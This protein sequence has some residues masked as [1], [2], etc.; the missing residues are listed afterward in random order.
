MIII[1]HRGNFAGPEP[2]VENHPSR[3]DA[4]IEEGFHVE[5]DLRCEGDQLWFGHDE[6]QYA[7]DPSWIQE[8][9]DRLF[10]H[11][12]DF[13]AFKH[14]AQHAPDRQF[15]CHSADPYTA[16]WGAEGYLLWLHDL[17]LVPDERT[18]VPLLSME[19][20]HGYPYRHVV[21]GICT[22][23]PREA[24]MLGLPSRMAE[25]VAP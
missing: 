23:W 2:A 24:R 7:I 13:A 11:L 5:V 17:S 10:L 6:A 19:Q 22:D 20:L 9:R 21:A 3:I 25:D 14:V 18:L 8:R 12:K 1:S 4:A 16:V 15:I